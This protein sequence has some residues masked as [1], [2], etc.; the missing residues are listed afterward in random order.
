MRVVSISTFNNKAFKKFS[1]MS[2]Y[3]FNLINQFVQSNGKYFIFPSSMLLLYCFIPGFT[4]SAYLQNKLMK[5][6]FTV[7]LQGYLVS[8]TVRKTMSWTEIYPRLVWQNGHCSSLDQLE[9]TQKANPAAGDVQA[10][11]KRSEQAAHR[12]SSR[13]L[14]PRVVLSGKAASPSRYQYQIERSGVRG[15]VR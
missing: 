14:N 11:A 2:S 15:R 12:S 5:S 7:D 3:S 4:V 8:F 10:W 9:T 1:K 6:L 13:S